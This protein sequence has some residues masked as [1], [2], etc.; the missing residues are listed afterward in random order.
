[1]TIAI[2]NRRFPARRAVLAVTTTV[3][4]AIAVLATVYLVT[5]TFLNDTPDSTTYA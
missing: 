2:S 5:Q 3:F 1:M 4:V